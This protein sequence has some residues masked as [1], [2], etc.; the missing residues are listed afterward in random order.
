MVGAS[1]IF[2][3]IKNN[4]LIQSALFGIKPAVVGLIFFSAFIL[5]KEHLVANNLLVALSLVFV[6]LFV[7]LRWNIHVI[8]ILLVAGCLGYFLS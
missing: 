1:E 3:R 7:M 4:K 5:L 8:W 2:L 6:S